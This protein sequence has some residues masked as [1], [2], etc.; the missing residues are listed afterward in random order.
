MSVRINLR[1]SKIVCTPVKVGVRT[2][3]M[4]IVKPCETTVRYPNI[5]P[6]V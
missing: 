4:S 3:C 5:A 1:M 2:Q 6:F